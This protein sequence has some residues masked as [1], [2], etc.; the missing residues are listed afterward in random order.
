MEKSS[1]K[2][3]GTSVI[4]KTQPEVNNRP[5]G[6]NS[7]ILVTLVAADLQGEMEGGDC[8]V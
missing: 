5:I 1:P 3:C 6:E 2:N 4:F 7:P 8:H